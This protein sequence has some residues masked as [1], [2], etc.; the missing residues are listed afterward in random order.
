MCLY[1]AD[2][3]FCSQNTTLEK[4]IRNNLFPVRNIVKAI[5]LQKWQNYTEG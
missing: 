1:D 2:L 3:S 5:K 4:H